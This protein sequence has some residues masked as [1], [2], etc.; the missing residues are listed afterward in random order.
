MMLLAGAAGGP[1]LGPHSLWQPPETFP[2]WADAEV[3]PV[4]VILMTIFV[5]SCES[6]IISK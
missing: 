6:I 1:H 2:S 5:T 4:L 3:R